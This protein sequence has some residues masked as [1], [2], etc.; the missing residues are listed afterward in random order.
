MNSNFKKMISAIA[1]V[2]LCV[3]AVPTVSEIAL[4]SSAATLLAAE[5]ETTNDSFSP[6]GGCSAAW[7]SDKAYSVDCSLFVSDRTATWNGAARDAS[8]FMAAGKTYNV[9]AAVYQE[10]GEAVEMKFSLQYKDEAGET[11]YDQIA[12]D[13]AASGEWLV[14]SNPT[15]TVPEG[16]KELQIYLETTESLCDFYVDL[17]KVNGAPSVIKTGDANGDLKVSTEDLTALSDFLLGASD[18]IEPGADYNNDGVIDTYDLVLLRQ[19][20]VAPPTG[21]SVSGDWDNYQEE[22][23]PQML[24]V[25]QDSLYR[26]GNTQR[27]REKISKAQN[28]EQVNIAYLGGSIT[29]GGSASTTQNSYAELSFNYFN[30]TFGAGGN[31]NYINAGLAGTSSVVGNL[32]VDN[33]VLSKNADII[34]IE[35]A[36]NDQG[37]DRFQKSFESLVKKCLSQPNEPAVVVIT[38]C[39]KSGSS[40]Q[41]WMV[42]VAENYDVPIISGKN[43]IMG[44]IDSGT[45]SWDADYGSGDTIHPGNGGHK[46]IADCIG[47]YYRQALRSENTSEEFIVS[48]K[49]VFGSEY[50]TARIITVDEMKNLSK[51]SWT[52]GTNNSQYSANGF[53]FSKNGNDPL[54]FTVEGKGIMLL[55]QSNS[56]ASMGT[57]MVNVNGNTNQVSSN[58]Q[59][60]WGG[61]DGDLGYYQ[62]QSGTLDVSISMKDPSTTFVLYGI[63]VIE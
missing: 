61:L 10:S 58:L 40:N 49:D 19:H 35:F 53:T 5:F 14:L 4:E 62:P 26:V 6:R 41:D 57:A 59:W 1:A 44:A 23:T 31:V 22:A 56:N 34:F 48:N 38:L 9:S 18:E 55:F 15:Y 50:A 36:V 60:T 63:A 21:P 29:A 17:V 8:S 51:G 33:E 16:A 37:G 46:L 20:L 25:Y 43:A 39:Q 42:Q 2:V 3:T 24:K 27:I 52:S 12:L 7:T 13:T 45:M 54:K 30:E 47:Y 28:G 32:R 11:K